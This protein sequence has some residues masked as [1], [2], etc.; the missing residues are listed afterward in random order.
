MRHT[1]AGF[2]TGLAVV[3]AQVDGRVVGMPANS[4]GSVS[5]DPPLVSLAFAHSSTTFPALERAERWGISVL[6]EDQALVLQNLR[7]P[8]AERFDGVDMVVED[9]AAFV[10]GALATIAITLRDRPSRGPRSGASAGHQPAPGPVAAS[11]GVLRQQ[12][13]HTLPPIGVL[14]DEQADDPWHGVDFWLRSPRR[15]LARTAREPRQL[16]RHRGEHPLCAGCRAR[17]LHV[18]VYPRLPCRARRRGGHRDPEHHRSDDGVGSHLPGHQSH[19]LRRHGIDHVP[20]TVHHRAPVQGAG[21]D[22]PRT[23]WVERGHHQR[24]DRSGQLRPARRRQRH[25]IPAR[26]RISADRAGAM[27][28][29]AAGRLDA[30]TPGPRTRPSVVSS[31]VPSC[32]PS[33]AAA[34][35]SPPADPWPSRRRNR[36]SR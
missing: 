2:T 19:R 36:G 32:S 3:A 12:N 34:S 30:W 5:L 26:P 15:R 23:R 24:P 28:Q 31:T 27:G 18:L 13:P 7:R 8:A 14:P 17:W 6:G 1:L 4:L 25:P 21:R 29:L 35:T 33:T 22:E 11:V 20:R 9:G 10:R 16:R